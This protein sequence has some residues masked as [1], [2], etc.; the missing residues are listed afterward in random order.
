[1]AEP[2][3]RLSDLSPDAPNSGSSGEP[4]FTGRVEHI[5][6]FVDALRT[7]RS[8]EH[9]VLVYHGIGG[10]GKSR[11]SRE[12][13]ALLAGN[14]AKAAEMDLPA[15]PAKLVD[16]AEHVPLCWGRL[17]FQEPQ[18]R[19]DAPLALFTMRA[20]LAERHGLRFPAF[21][22]AYAEWWTKTNPN[23]PLAQ[24]DLPFLEEGDFLIECASIAQDIPGAGLITKIPK[25]IQKLGQKV[26]NY[27]LQQRM[28]SLKHL[29]AMKANEIA[30]YLPVF[31]AQDLQDEMAQRDRRVVLFL[32]TYEA[33][34]DG[35]RAEN[36][37]HRL[38]AW[39]REW[40]AQLP[41]VLWVVSGRDK[42]YWRE[43]DNDWTGDLT[44]HL[45]GGLSEPDVRG[46]LTDSGITDTRL[47][48]VCH[49]SH[50]EGR[51][52]RLR[53]RSRDLSRKASE[54]RDAKAGGLY[55]HAAGSP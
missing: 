4:P 33:L 55:R 19:A 22:L 48:G 7:Q 29:P 11:L 34:R 17:D 44:H 14:S 27:R 23:V 20:R 24:S 50:G 32:D 47:Q 21:D 41:G 40:V 36:Q 51:A 18:L 38:D 26:Q 15:D 13:E 31:W 37:R 28:E 16:S 46:L 42:L 5:R 12:L 52:V 45:V 39:V 53:T 2:Q 30:D 3:K 1:M 25:L 49:H 54:W 35:R 9:R 43:V 8:D 10:I 6:S